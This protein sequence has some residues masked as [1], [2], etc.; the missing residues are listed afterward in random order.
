MFREVLPS[1]NV[2]ERKKRRNFRNFSLLK[3]LKMKINKIENDNIRT[4]SLLKAF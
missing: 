2:K 4:E 3:K 1:I